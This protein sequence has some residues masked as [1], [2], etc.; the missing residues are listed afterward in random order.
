MPEATDEA[1]LPDL[2]H[3]SPRLRIDVEH[4]KLTVSLAFASGVA[5]GLFTEALD[6]A[7]VASSSWHPQAF[8][9]DLFVNQFASLCFGFEI[10][11]APV[12][13]ATKHLVNVL[14]HPPSDE[15]VVEHRRAILAELVASSDLRAGLERLY[16]LLGR[17]RGLL[18]GATGIGKWDPNRRQLDILSITKEIL[19]C[20]AERFASAESGLKRLHTYAERVRAG[21]PYRSLA[22]LLRYDERL[23]TL[24]L[25]VS[26]GADGNLRG[27]E[28]L[29]IKE[30]A[31]NPFVASAPRRW[32]SKLELFARGFHFGEAEVISRLIDAVFEG[33]VDEIVRFVQLF[34]D[35]E[36]YLGTL[37]FRDRALAAG[38]SVC[39]PEFVEASAPRKLVRFFN[40]LLLVHDMK[41]VP[42]DISLDRHDA[43]VLVTGPNSGGKTRL[44]QSIALAQLVAQCGFFVSA[45]S[46]T[47]ARAPSLVVSLI[48]E[49]KADQAEGRLGMELVRIRQL[50]EQLPPGAMVILDELCSG[51]NPSEGEEIFELVIRMLERLRP[52]T[53]ITT[54]FLAFAARLEKEKSIEGL[55]FLQVV[56]GEHHEPT[57]QFEPGVAKTSLAG[58][59]AARLGVTGDQLLALIERN[60]RASRS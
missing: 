53:F 33:L 49:T 15:A 24:D 35:V 27:F 6:R 43:I 5:G 40:P 22:D 21:E 4:T 60:I 9:R 20:M 42:C 57:F 26:V 11:G 52:Q 17:L 31:E 29:S 36:V 59:T 3:P 18:E 32:L 41:P 47:I 37:G 30:D 38:L 51:T 44:L 50:F 56:L 12:V 25:R 28:I 34:G 1:P 58:Q 19:D 2:L 55:R 8:A 45:K 7:S 54:H 23:A 13:L 14:T 16:L 48:Q 10:E 46:A 39:L